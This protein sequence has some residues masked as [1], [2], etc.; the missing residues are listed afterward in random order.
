[1]F[2]WK[3]VA[4]AAAVVMAGSA[5]AFADTY[6]GDL[7][8]TLFSGGA[9]VNKV[10]YSYDDST[11]SFSLGAPQNIAHAN[12]ADGII[13]DSLGHLLVG[14]QGS[15]SVHMYDPNTGALLDDGFLTTNSYHLAL[16]PSGAYVYTSTFGGPLEVLPLSGASV[17][18]A[19]QYSLSPAP[20]VLGDFDMTGLAYAP[21]TSTW[22]YVNGGPNDTA[23]SAS[24]T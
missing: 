4:A 23:T 16:D 12:G 1:M 7:F 15:N 18:N 19:T 8:Y 17:G 20:S 24:W 3:A 9:N 13:F 6:G 2:N 21:D 11:N 10:V 5:P 22:F 14:G